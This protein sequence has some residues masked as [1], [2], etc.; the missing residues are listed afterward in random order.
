[1]AIESLPMP[2]SNEEQRRRYATDPEYREKKQEYA[3]RW[4]LKNP[5]K[6][7]ESWIKSKRREQGIL[8]PSGE[9]RYGS[10]ENSSCSFNGQLYYDH[11]HK[12]GLFRGWLCCA[13]NLAA[14]NCADDPERLVGL[15]D[16]LRRK[17]LGD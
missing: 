10:C 15:A 3:R 13:C 11:D 9:I 7:R 2:M 8:N 17:L 6:W 16:Y 5:E 4:R 14:G 12:T 1:M